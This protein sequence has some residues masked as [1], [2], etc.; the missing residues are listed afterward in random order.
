MFILHNRRHKLPATLFI[1]CIIAL[2][3]FKDTGIFVKDY[4]GAKGED[5][6]IEF[7][8]EESIDI[9]KETKMIT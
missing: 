2:L 1:V 8:K 6:Q 5:E 3:G 7:V 9:L 4:V